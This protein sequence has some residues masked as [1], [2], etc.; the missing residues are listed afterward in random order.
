MCV[1]GGVWV[2]MCVSARMCVHVYARQIAS[3]CACMWACVYEHV[4]KCQC[5]GSS[6]LYK[7][8]QLSNWC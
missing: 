3:V 7:R 8:N 6:G 5:V 4:S 1:C 2:W